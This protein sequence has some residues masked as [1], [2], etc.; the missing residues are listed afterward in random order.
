MTDLYSN[1]TDLLGDV[2]DAAPK[3]LIVVTGYPYLVESTAPYDSILITAINKATAALNTTIEAAV[4]ATHNDNIVYVDV[5]D[6]FKNHGIGSSDPFIN[7]PTT[8]VPGAVPFH[9]NAVGYQ[10]YAD[11]ISAA[12]QEARQEQ[13]T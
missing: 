10:A 4:I 9:P 5:T 1:L 3:A 13:L 8:G 2:A 12:I 7:D 11:A 6:K